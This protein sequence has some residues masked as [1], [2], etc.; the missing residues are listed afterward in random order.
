MEAA[1]QG[2]RGRCGAQGRGEF[3]VGERSRC[4]EGHYDD[5]SVSEAPEQDVVEWGSSCGYRQGRRHDRAEHGHHALLRNDRCRRPQIHAPIDALV[6]RERL[7]QFHLG[8]RRRIDQR[9]DRCDLLSK[10]THGRRRSAEG[11]RRSVDGNHQGPIGRPRPERRGH[12][13]RHA[14]LHRQLSG[15]RRRRSSTRPTHRQLPAVQVRR[16]RQRSQHRPLGRRDRFVHGQ[17]LRGGGVGRFDRDFGWKGDF[18]EQQVHIG[19][20]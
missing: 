16:F 9:Y 8:R 17:V 11:V 12:R 2:A 19:G 13:T 18:R 4:G 15:K 20:R 1:G 14:N 6:G 5:G 10:G 7:V 3:A